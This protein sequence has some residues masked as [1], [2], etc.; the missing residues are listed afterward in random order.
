MYDRWWLWLKEQPLIL[1]ISA[2]LLTLPGSPA[3]TREGTSDLNL[4]SREIDEEVVCA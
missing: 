4:Y 2:S 3:A 1:V